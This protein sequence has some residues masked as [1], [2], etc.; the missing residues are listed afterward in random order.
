MIIVVIK[1][2][3]AIVIVWHIFVIKKMVAFTSNPILIAKQENLSSSSSSRKR[4]KMLDLGLCGCLSVVQRFHDLCPKREQ[5]RFTNWGKRRKRVSVGSGNCVQRWLAAGQKR[6]WW[7]WLS[8]E[9]PQSKAWKGRARLQTQP[10]LRPLDCLIES[11]RSD[12]CREQKIFQ[13]RNYS[14][15]GGTNCEVSS[16]R[17]FFGS[18]R[19]NNIFATKSTIF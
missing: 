14:E 16:P 6:K 13:P 19:V 3:M 1:A 15:Q 18:Q 12:I 2:V 17:K 11:F 5:K 8:L 7:K 10:G 4:Q 9:G